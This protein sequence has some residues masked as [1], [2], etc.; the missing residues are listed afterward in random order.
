[1]KNSI[2]GILCIV[3]LSLHG[4]A[5]EIDTTK[6][7]IDDVHVE[8][9]FVPDVK[10]AKPLGIDPTVKKS[11]YVPA[12]YSY[13]IGLVPLDIT[14]TLPGLKPLALSPEERPD[15]QRSYIKLGY[16]NLVNPY[17]ELSHQFYRSDLYDINV[18]GR[19]HGALAEDLADR[20]YHDANVGVM[21][22]Y[23]L[24]ENSYFYFDIGSRYQ[25]KINAINYRPLNSFLTHG[26]IGFRN[27]EPDH[28]LDYDISLGVDQA[29][30]D[31][32]N[33]TETS[34]LETLRLSYPLNDNINVLFEN[35]IYITSNDG[36]LKDAR[37]QYISL[38][39]GLMYKN[40]KLRLQALY[41]GSWIEGKLSHFVDIYASF[42]I[43]E[44]MFQIY[45]GVDRDLHT[46]N[47]FDMYQ[48]NP[49]FT[50]RDTSYNVVISEER[51][52]Y[53]GLRSNLMNKVTLDAR[54]GYK[55][56]DNFRH[57]IVES[58]KFVPQFTSLN[59]VFLEA[60]IDVRP[61]Q[62]L[63]LKW[64]GNVDIPTGDV[65]IYNTPFFH[66]EVRTKYQL[67]DRIRVIGEYILGDNISVFAPLSNKELSLSYL[68]EF[69][70]EVQFRINK[71]VS[72][73]ARAN[74]I[75]DQRYVRFYDNPSIGFQVL[76]G[77]IAR[78]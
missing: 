9:V 34:Y 47:T 49:Y 8:K 51:K 41:D 32:P 75:F 76:G 28:G 71:N 45:G 52:Y 30:T 70:A 42:A 1:M 60:L 48:H 69:N 67:T 50:T 21:G 26:R 14:Y 59:R 5:Q 78:F 16:G 43:Y 65:K 2:I 4:L 22:N 27:V 68:N 12:R 19:Y 25:N 62:R 35:D 58:P 23:R 66:S 18:Y 55:E 20:A 56:T 31:V 36:A 61:T 33:S 57:Y 63:Q 77:V 64:I 54:V 72:L 29:N 53:A 13:D 6:I 73:W 3:L 37:S 46:H 11:S 44:D 17:G 38:L 74:N 40:D 15:L 24:F 7:Q 39:P 10:N